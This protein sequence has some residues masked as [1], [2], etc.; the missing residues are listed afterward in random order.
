[1]LNAPQRAAQRVSKAEFADVSR[2]V[3]AGM[4]TDTALQ[5]ATALPATAE[6]MARG[7]AFTPEETVSVS[8][9]GGD[10]A[11]ALTHAPR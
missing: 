8:P 2:G 7:T 10:A 6:R 5:S 9:R 4:E 1:M 3:I 11:G